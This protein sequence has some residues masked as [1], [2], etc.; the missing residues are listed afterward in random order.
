MITITTRNHLR[1]TRS[2]QFCK[3]C[4]SLLQFSQPSYLIIL[5]V[6]APG[7]MSEQENTFTVHVCPACNTHSD[8]ALIAGLWT[9]VLEHYNTEFET[10]YMKAMMKQEQPCR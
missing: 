9:W 8:S 4:N 5:R 2:E 7:K 1:H 6:T 3:C 10:L